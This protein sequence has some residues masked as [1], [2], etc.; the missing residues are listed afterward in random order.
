MD[1]ANF[2]IIRKFNK[3]EDIKYFICGHDGDIEFGYTKINFSSDLGIIG[4]LSDGSL[5]LST[6]NNEETLV[7]R[8]DKYFKPHTT[9]GN[10]IFVINGDIIND[11]LKPSAND[12]D[13]YNI[14]IDF[15]LKFT[16]AAKVEK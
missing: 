11:K 14:F 15:F 6:T 10:R 3:P 12:L 8:L 16:P 4:D 9:L 1:I 7:I 2:Y 5:L 13:I